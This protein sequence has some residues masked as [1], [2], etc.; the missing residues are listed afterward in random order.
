MYTSRHEARELVRYATTTP[1]GLQAGCASGYRHLAAAHSLN[2][3]ES[4]NAGS[5]SFF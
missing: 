5:E 3:Y 1:Q 2:L 4:N